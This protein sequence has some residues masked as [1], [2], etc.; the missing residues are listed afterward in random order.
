MK[1]KINLL[2]MRKLAVLGVAA[3]ISAPV[4]AA[5]DLKADAPPLHAV[6]GK[7]KLNLDIYTWG[8]IPPHPPADA[9]GLFHGW[10]PGNPRNERGE[11]TWVKHLSHVGYAGL[12][13]AGLAASIASGGVAPAIGFGIVTVVQ[14]FL[15]W[16]QIKN[17]SSDKSD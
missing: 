14:L 5:L 12:G 9:A 7:G 4:T 6:R 17:S 8:K 10:V 11:P 1:A 3:L 16:R 15:E 13:A 2:L